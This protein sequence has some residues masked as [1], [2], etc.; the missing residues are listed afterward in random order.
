MLSTDPDCSIR[1]HKKLPN[2]PPPPPINGLLSMRSRFLSHF[3][4]VGVGYE[5]LGEETIFFKV[6]AER[7]SSF[8]LLFV[9]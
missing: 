6:C 1:I 8:S 9:T 2:L 4:G 7:Y 3:I 5:V